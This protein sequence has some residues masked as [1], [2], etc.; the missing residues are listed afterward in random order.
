MKEAIRKNEILDIVNKYNYVTVEYLS[1]TLHISQ[2][3]IRRDLTILEAQN[4][5][6]RAHGG[7]HAITY[8]NTLTPYELRIQEN[9][10]AKRTICQKAID[11][12]QDG[13]TVFIDGSTTC[14]YL[15][16]LLEKKNNITVLTNSLKLSAMFEK[17]R[18]IT[19]YCTGGLLRLNEQVATGSLAEA[20]CRFIHTN[21]MFFSARA[22][23]ANGLITDINEPE[24]AI[25]KIA[26]QNTDK[27]VFLCDSTK[28]NQSSTFTVCSLQDVAYM[29]TETAPNPDIC[30]HWKTDR[31]L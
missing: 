19:V 13:D 9:S 16:D 4:L 3:S 15:P 8:G 12:V 18:N 10:I 24:T 22:I 11:L 23:D 2:S 7:V 5:V 25:R 27:A 29:I 1:K 30:K 17:S 6:K 14:L 20:A 28:F 31:I 26:M 21:I